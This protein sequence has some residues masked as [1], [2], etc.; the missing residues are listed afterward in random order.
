MCQLWI[1]Q[2]SKWCH[3]VQ[4]DLQQS[5]WLYSSWLFLLCTISSFVS[6]GTSWEGILLP[7][8]SP[9][10][11]ICKPFWKLRCR[12]TR[13]TGKRRDCST[14]LTA[15]SLSKLSMYTHT[16]C[17]KKHVKVIEINSLRTSQSCGHLFVNTMR[18]MTWI[19]HANVRDQLCGCTCNYYILERMLI[20]M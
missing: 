13:K 17:Q 16:L 19:F 1:T 7:S 5:I 6:T 20:K 4:D 3:S 15:C 10:A 9:W 18:I 8:T 12:R 14:S 2:F 11:S